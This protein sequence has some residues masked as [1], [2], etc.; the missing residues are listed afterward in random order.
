MALTILRNVY[1]NWMKFVNTR[2]I[3]TKCPFNFR[4][5]KRWVF[6]CLW[7]QSIIP[8]DIVAEENN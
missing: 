7:K 3:I 4:V 1:E 8:V 2:I 5:S 6:P